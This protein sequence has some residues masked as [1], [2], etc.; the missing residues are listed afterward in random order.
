MNKAV[1]EQNWGISFS[2]NFQCVHNVEAYNL[3][4]KKVKLLFTLILKGKIML[5]LAPWPSG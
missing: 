1:K 5:G 3:I 4:V 2:R